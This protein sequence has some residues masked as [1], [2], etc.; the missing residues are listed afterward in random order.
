M[1]GGRYGSVA[2][3]TSFEGQGEKGEGEVW[4]VVSERKTQM[5]KNARF[6]LINTTK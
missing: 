6:I 1:G 3:V 4:V 5:H 2:F